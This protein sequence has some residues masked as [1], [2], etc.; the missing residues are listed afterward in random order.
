MV[1]SGWENAPTPQPTKGNSPYL[2][3]PDLLAT[4]KSTLLADECIVKFAIST[5]FIVTSSLIV[6]SSTYRS[7]EL[8]VNQIVAHPKARPTND[9]RVSPI[10]SSV[11]V[12]FYGGSQQFVQLA[13]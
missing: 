13:S 6:A 12:C 2:L 9:G 4:I 8:Q 3:L 5:Q 1:Y 7:Y 10:A 11:S